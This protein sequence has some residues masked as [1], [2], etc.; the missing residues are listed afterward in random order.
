M[1]VSKEA[2]LILNY[3]FWSIRFWEFCVNSSFASL[4][5]WLQ[6]RGEFFTEKTNAPV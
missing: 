2:N 6:A 5:E 1:G 3:L 4:R